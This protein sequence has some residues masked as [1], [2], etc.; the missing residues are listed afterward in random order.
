MSVYY[1][2]AVY[3]VHKIYTYLRSLLSSE[4]FH[5]LT[6]SRFD[7]FKYAYAYFLAGREEKENADHMSRPRLFPYVVFSTTSD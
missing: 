6:S 5:I 3:T 1:V 4:L 7:G 2:P